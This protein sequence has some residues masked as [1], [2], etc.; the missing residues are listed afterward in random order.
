[1]SLEQANFCKEYF[2]CEFVE[3]KINVIKTSDIITKEYVDFIS[4]DTESWDTLVIKGI[5]NTFF[6]NQNIYKL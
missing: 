3:Q 6:E 1:M 2:K 5:G 4:I